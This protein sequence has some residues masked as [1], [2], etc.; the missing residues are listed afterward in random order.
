MQCPINKNNDCEKC[1]WFLANQYP[2]SLK[3][4]GRCSVSAI[5]AFCDIILKEYHQKK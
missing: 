1:H 3:P 4:N 2:T 5:A